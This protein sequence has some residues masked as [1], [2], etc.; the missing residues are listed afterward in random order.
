MQKHASDIAKLRNGYQKEINAAIHR[1][2]E[3][4]KNITEKE[5]AIE[6]QQKEI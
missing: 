6:R 3:A 1:A 4:E 5:M 2:E